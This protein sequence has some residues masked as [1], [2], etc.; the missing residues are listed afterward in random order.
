MMALKGGEKKMNSSMT[1]SVSPVGPKERVAGRVA[2]PGGDR[3]KPPH[4]RTALPPLLALSMVQILAQWERIPPSTRVRTETHPTNDSPPADR[5]VKRPSLRA[6]SPVAVGPVTVPLT[7]GEAAPTD[8]APLGRPRPVQMSAAPLHLVA[9]RGSGAVPDES[10]APNRKARA[11]AISRVLPRGSAARVS[12]NEGPPARPRVVLKPRFPVRSVRP[13][14]AAAFSKVSSALAKGAKTTTV[15][16]SADEVPIPPARAIPAVVLR[17]PGGA[18]AARAGGTAS[19]PATG[20]QSAA[21]PVLARGWRV[22]RLTVRPPALSGQSVQFRLVPPG[23]KLSAVEVRLVTGPGASRVTLA[24]P[25]MAWLRGL[26]ADKGALTAQLEAQ[27]GSTTVQVT[28]AGGFGLGQ[29]HPGADGSSRPPPAAP[30]G[31]RAPGPDRSHL[32]PS[33]GRGLDFRA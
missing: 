11:A 10:G 30:G 17:P 13:T 5:M 27:L 32:D 23:A 28:T 9:S 4:G 8:R 25:T 7:G 24:V 6:G 21:E 20:A 19:V 16:Q 12:G 31:G 18:N 33:E 1:V 3:G 29:G 26:D 2:A 14:R 22:E 15:S